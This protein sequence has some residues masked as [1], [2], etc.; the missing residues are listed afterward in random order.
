MIDRTTNLGGR[1]LI[2]AV[3]N[4]DANGF[5]TPSLVTYDGTIYPD[6]GTPFNFTGGKPTQY[7]P[8]D[9]VQLAAAK[10]GHLGTAMMIGG[11]WHFIIGEGT[12]LAECAPE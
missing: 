4:V 3:N 1:V 11:Q 9:L 10:A 6:K 8:P 5:G 2:T 12:K 7:R